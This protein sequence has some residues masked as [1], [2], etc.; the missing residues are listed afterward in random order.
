MIGDPTVEIPDL[1]APISAWRAF[2][3]KGD[4][5]SPTIRSMNDVDWPK[6]GEESFL[7][8]TCIPMSDRFDNPPHDVPSPIEM[9]ATHPGVGCGI[10]SYKELVYLRTSYPVQFLPYAMWGPPVAPF[11]WG[12]ILI[13]G[14]VYEYEK[15]YRSQYAQLVGLLSVPDSRSGPQVVTRVA[16]FYNLPLE[17]LPE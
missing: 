14:H 13:W 7:T 6:P 1:V 5:D 16:E 11:V 3:V 15:G 12:R 9:A 10:Y 4:E 8:A 2:K 17:S